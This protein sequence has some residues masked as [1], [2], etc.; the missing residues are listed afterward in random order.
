MKYNWDDL[1]SNDCTTP[2]A[3]PSDSRVNSVN[4][5]TNVES[6]I[7]VGCPDFVGNVDDERCL[8]KYPGGSDADK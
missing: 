1:H 4:I 5:R 2:S 6:D 3:G 7:D 8:T